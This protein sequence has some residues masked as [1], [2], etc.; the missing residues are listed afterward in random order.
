MISIKVYSSNG[1][2]PRMLC[3]RN[4]PVTIV[5]GG[6]KISAEPDLGLL[7]LLGLNDPS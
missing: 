6:T 5:T 1:P 3:V 4:R 7:P 2:H